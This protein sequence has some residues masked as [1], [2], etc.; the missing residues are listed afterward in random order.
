M[1]PFGARVLKVR[2]GSVNIAKAMK[3]A[4][5]GPGAKL[6]VQLVRANTTAEISRF[7]IRD[8]RKP[9]AATLCEASPDPEPHRC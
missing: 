3:G 5:F 7:T 4:R 9:L 2:N 1:G 6:E 8:N